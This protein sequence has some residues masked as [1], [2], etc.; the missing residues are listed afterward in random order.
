MLFNGNSILRS[1]MD[2]LK[3][4]SKFNIEFISSFSL[5]HPEQDHNHFRHTDDS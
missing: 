5:H 4:E 3:V 1:R 2:E